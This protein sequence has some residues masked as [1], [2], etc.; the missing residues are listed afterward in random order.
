MHALWSKCA[1]PTERSRMATFA[2]AGS[3]IGTVVTFSIGGLIG[4]YINWQAIF[5]VSGSV[6]MIFTVMWFYFISESPALHKTITEEE[7]N[8]IESC[9]VKV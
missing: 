4:K 7:K 2:L 8:Y 6:G 1:P 3:H 5:Y 9:Y